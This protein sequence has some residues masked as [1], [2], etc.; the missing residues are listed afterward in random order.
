[1]G[2]WKR[3][4]RVIALSSNHLLW[5][6]HWFLLSIGW[7]APWLIGKLTGTET[8]VGA[9]HLAAR[10]ALTACLIPYLTMILVD[11]K[12]RPAKPSWWRWRHQAVAL[13][14]WVF[15]PLTSFVFSTVPALVAQTRL[16]LGRRLEYRVTEKA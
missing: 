8:E 1:M 4:R 6:T 13:A 7:G 11:G 16:M 12:L 10:V 5:S 3:T 15:L 9:L 14:M 2:W